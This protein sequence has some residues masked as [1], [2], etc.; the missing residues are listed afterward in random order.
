MK[1]MVS[2]LIHVTT[3]LGINWTQQKGEASILHFVVIDI[4]IFSS[5]DSLNPT[6]AKLV[7]SFMYRVLVK[8]YDHDGDYIK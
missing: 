5:V 6:C 2:V 8:P 7:H 4:T 3:S 1:I